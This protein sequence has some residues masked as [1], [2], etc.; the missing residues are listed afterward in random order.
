M[1]AKGERR[2]EPG[3]DGKL[4]EEVKFSNSARRVGTDD[5]VSYAVSREKMGAYIHH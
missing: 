4:V 1:E 5:C 2:G 3:K